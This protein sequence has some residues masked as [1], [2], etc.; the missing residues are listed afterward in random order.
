MASRAWGKEV[1]PHVQALEIQQHARE[2]LG[3]RGAA[4]QVGVP[5]GVLAHVAAQQLPARVLGQQ[6]A[7]VMRVDDQISV[8]QQAFRPVEIRQPA[9]G[10]TPH[11]EVTREVDALGDHARS[12]RDF[13]VH[14]ERERNRDAGAPVEHFVE[15]AV[16]RV[17]VLDIVADETLFAKQVIVE[18]GHARIRFGVGVR[19]RVGGHRR[20]RRDPL[21]RFTPERVELVEVRPGVEPGVTP[22]GQS[23][24][25]RPRDSGSGLSAR[26]VK[27]WTSC[28]ET[29]QKQDTTSRETLAKSSFA[30]LRA[31]ARSGR[32]M[33]VAAL[34]A[35]CKT[36]GSAPSQ[37]SAL[38]PSSHLRP[39]L[40]RTD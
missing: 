39:E 37:S 40:W 2:N 17:L 19:G 8:R 30:P 22:R 20:S 23:S 12:P 13:H 36:V 1:H 6:R 25:R 10:G 16:A 24:A 26:R 28:S 18:S 34:S 15:K 33:R 29:I 3:L 27:L 5:D 31:L 38:W 11:E 21:C 35:T 7:A 14:A 9:A 32:R 4:G